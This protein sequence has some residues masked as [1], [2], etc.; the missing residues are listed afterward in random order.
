M[1]HAPKECACCGGTERRLLIRV[2]DWTVYKCSACGL[3][4]LDP[5]PD[6]LELSAL[7]RESYF[8]SH[9][10]D[11]L[12]PG[13]PGMQRRISQEAHRIR[14]FG[15]FK[16]NGLVLDIGCG[17]GYFLHACRIR[18]YDVVGLD[19]SEDAAASVWN[20]LRI[21]IK[22]GRLRDELFAAE[23][24]DVIT[25]WHA[26]EHT[27]DPGR[28]LI[29]AWRWL[30]PGGLLVVDVPNHEGTDARKK[31]DR[32]EDWDLPYHL[33]HFTPAT[34]GAMISRCGFLPLRSKT[35]H[36]EYVKEKLRKI[37]VIG[38]LARPVAKF[39]SGTSC[40]IV[41]EKTERPHG[42]G[43]NAGAK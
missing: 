27:E 13:S 36:S 2:G 9:Y 10:E 17:R 43:A 24:I 15:K 40:A 30:R 39:Y 32:W 3:G 21:P 20:T 37:P 33:Y 23:S 28:Y 38:L 7:Y 12:E 19:V 8:A 18:G 41:A 26:L 4:V 22:T 35:Y 1:E 29:Q 25:M 42:G 11:A 14:F 6:P 34:L 31:W 5:R 16:R